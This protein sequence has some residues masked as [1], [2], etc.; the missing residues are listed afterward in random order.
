M[1]VGFKTAVLLRY[2]DVTEEW[3]HVT[4]KLFSRE[5]IAVWTVFGTA[6]L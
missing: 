6:Y 3:W 4:G 5:G 2:G 1:G